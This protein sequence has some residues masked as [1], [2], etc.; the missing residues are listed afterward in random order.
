MIG[1]N[2]DIIES[3]LAEFKILKAQNEL[4]DAQHIDRVDGCEI[5]RENRS[6]IWTTEMYHIHELPLDYSTTIATS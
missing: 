3:K 2:F 5:D 1:V 4:E 6:I